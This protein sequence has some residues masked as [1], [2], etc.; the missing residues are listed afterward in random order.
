MGRVVD[1]RDL[2]SFEV[3][4]AIS[5]LLQFREFSRCRLQEAKS[6]IRKSIRNLSS[7]F[8]IEVFSG[9]FMSPGPQRVLL[10]SKP[11]AVI[12]LRRCSIG[13]R[14]ISSHADDPGRG[15]GRC[16]VYECRCDG[17]SCLVDRRRT[18]VRRSVTRHDRPRRV[19]A[20]RRVAQ[21]GG[22]HTPAPS[23]HHQNPLAGS[24]RSVLP[25]AL[26]DSITH[27]LQYGRKIGINMDS[28]ER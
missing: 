19:P 18:V 16:G 13:L 28:M 23:G 9:A 24:L 1:E 10:G 3:A 22:C 2:S 25:P 8:L 20:C 26:P 5:N 12:Q 4:N 7:P 15:D 27:R 11:T 21:V 6:S 17:M 14:I